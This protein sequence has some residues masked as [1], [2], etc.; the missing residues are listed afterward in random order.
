MP[1]SSLSS[2]KSLPRANP[3]RSETVKDQIQN[4]ALMLLNNDFFKH[5]TE[6]KQPPQLLATENI[7]CS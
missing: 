4:S 6:P 7:M 2:L 3:D 5:K 1:T